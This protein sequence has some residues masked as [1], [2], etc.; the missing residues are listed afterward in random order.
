V[1]CGW[2]EPWGGWGCVGGLHQLFGGAWE[3][4]GGC[5][6][7]PVFAVEN[8]GVGGGGARPVKCT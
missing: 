8:K 4:A 5:K 2:V 1:I 6:R 3:P 7:R